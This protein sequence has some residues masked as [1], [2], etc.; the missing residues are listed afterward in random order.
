M[1]E[2]IDA[3]QVL[4]AAIIVAY[5]AIKAARGGINVNVK[6]EHKDN[7]PPPPA[8]RDHPHHNDHKP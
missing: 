2:A 7:Y 3:L 8:D 4:G 1:R 5:A 6:H